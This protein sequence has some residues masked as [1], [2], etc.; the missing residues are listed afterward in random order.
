MN[1]HLAL[2]QSQL[3]RL[4]APSLFAV[5][6]PVALL[7]A[8][9]AAEFESEWL[10]VHQVLGPTSASVSA[11]EQAAFKQVYAASGATDFNEFAPLVSE[12][13][14]L[15]ARALCQDFS[16]PW[17]SGLFACY[18]QGVFPCGHVQPVTSS[19]PAL[20]SAT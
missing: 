11:V 10:R 13:F 1:A 18:Q 16:D 8:R 14:G 7:D 15:F 19:L 17:L 12:D 5:A 2:L 20:L 4:I 9:D 6:D 3:S